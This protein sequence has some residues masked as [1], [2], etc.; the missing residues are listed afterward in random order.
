MASSSVNTAIDNL[1]NL[2]INELSTSSSP[3]LQKNLSILSPDQ[4]ELAKMLLEM[5]QAHLFEDWPDPGVE[6][7]E[8]IAFIDQIDLVVDRST[9]LLL[10]NFVTFII[11]Y[12]N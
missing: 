12:P 1:F 6:D 5:R 2:Q 7:D 4:V 9:I 11:L 8:K 10:N 3:N